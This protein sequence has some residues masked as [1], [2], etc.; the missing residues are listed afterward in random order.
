MHMDNS[1][2]RQRII[3]GGIALNKADVHVGLLP[4]RR[5]DTHRG[6]RHNKP[7]TPVTQKKI[8]ISLNSAWNL[9]NF[10]AGLIQALSR[11]GHEV[12]AIAPADDYAGRLPALGCRFVPLLMNATG[13]NPLQDISLLRAYWKL[14]SAE[15]P[16][17]YLG[18]TI[19]PNIYG[20]IAASALNIPTINNIAGLGKAFQSD[21]WLTHVVAHLYRA[22]LKPAKM[23]LFQNEEDHAAF[24]AK[25]IVSAQKSLRVP[26]SGVDIARFDLAPVEPVTDGQPFRFLLAA[27]LLWEKGIAEYVEAARIL[28]ARGRNIDCAIA[29]FPAGDPQLGATQ[30]QLEAWSR[31]GSI[32]Y[33][34][35]SDHIAAELSQ[36]DCVVLPSCYREGVPRILLES[37]AARRPIVT[38]DWIGCRD[39]VDHMVNGFLCQ[40]RDASDLALAMERMM[41]TPL[42]ERQ[43]MGERGRAKVSSSFSEA[44][45]IDVYRQLLAQLPSQRR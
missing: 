32:R 43:A 38:T 20:S 45:V 14:L 18:F 36:A 28:R 5:I 2:L 37:A 31:D 15:R 22:A 24:L 27:R 34:G 13:T 40:P 26:G 17:A 19:K 21:G 10:R 25:S 12:V 9:Y 41:D 29:G 42:A 4:C 6:Q 39:A 7:K 1:P 11:D 8:V 35:V 16:D 3:I 23:V 30:S 44:S 33:L